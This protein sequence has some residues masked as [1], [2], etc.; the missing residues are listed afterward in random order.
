MIKRHLVNVY[1]PSTDVDD[2]GQRT[3]GVTEILVDVPCAI[4]QLSGLEL[5]RAKKLFAEATYSVE[6]WGDPDTPILTTDQIIWGLRVLHIGAV[7]DEEQTG[8][9]I[10]VLCRE[11]L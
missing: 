3:G 10:Q 4:K 8:V 11:E 7:V 2:R 5:I 6:L 9:A 1:R